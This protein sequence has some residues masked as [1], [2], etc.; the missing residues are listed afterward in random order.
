MAED[1][2]TF[3][4]KKRVPV[5]I[6]Y[7]GSLFRIRFLDDPFGVTKELLLIL[8]RMNGVETSPSGNCFLTLAHSD[9]DIAVTAAAMKESINTL[10][11]EDFFHEPA[12]IETEKQNEVR[13]VAV[14]LEMRD[15]RANA[16]ES[17]DQMEKLRKLIA[18]D[19]KSFQKK[20]DVA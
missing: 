1:L 10:L 3:F 2:N 17:N 5:V 9:E 7:F 11:R 15:G 8:L 12:A 19:L 6:D 20:R 16:S 4:S 18:A 14:N 13:K